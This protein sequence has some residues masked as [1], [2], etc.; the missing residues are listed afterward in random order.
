MDIYQKYSQALETAIGLIQSEKLDPT[1]ALQKTAEIMDLE[2]P[3]VEYVASQLNNSRALVHMA[4][5]S[6]ESRLAP[7]PLADSSKVKTKADRKPKKAEVCKKAS[8]D[9]IF[10]PLLDL[11]LRGITKTAHAEPAPTKVDPF[12]EFDSVLQA[13]KDLLEATLRLHRAYADDVKRLRNRCSDTANAIVHTAGSDDFQEIHRKS[14]RGS[15][16]RVSAAKLASTYENLKNAEYAVTNVQHLAGTGFTSDFLANSAALGLSKRLMSSSTSLNNASMQADLVTGDRIKDMGLAD[17]S[18]VTAAKLDGLRTRKVFMDAVF[19]DPGLRG[20]PLAKLVQAF[21]DTVQTDPSIVRSPPRIRAGMMQM[22]QSSV[23][24]PFQLG[25]M[26]DT[27]KK[28]QAIFKEIRNARETFKDDIKAVN[29]KAA[30]KMAERATATQ[31]AEALAKAEAEKNTLGGAL[32]ELGTGLRTLAAVPE[33]YQTRA[34]EERRLSSLFNSYSAEDLEAVAKANGFKSAYD[35]KTV[36]LR[37][38]KRN[39]GSSLGSATKSALTGIQSLQTP[40]EKAAAEANIKREEA[41]ID[42]LLNSLDAADQETLAKEN[43]FADASQMRQAMMQKVRDTAGKSPVTGDTAVDSAAKGLK[44]LKTPEEKA[45]DA[46]LLQRE[47][48]RINRYFQ[49]YTPEELEAVALENG[50]SSVDEYK[51]ELLRQARENPGKS[52]ISKFDATRAAVS[53]MD[54][55]DDMRNT[56]AKDRDKVADKVIESK[57]KEIGKIDRTYLNQAVKLADEELKAAARGNP[58]APFSLHEL[59]SSAL[60]TLDADATSEF[61]AKMAEI[62]ARARAMKFADDVSGKARRSGGSKLTPEQIAAIQEVEFRTRLDPTAPIDPTAAGVA[63]AALR[64]YEGARLMEEAVKVERQMKV[65][66]SVSQKKAAED[67]ARQ[68]GMTYAELLSTLAASE[69]PGGV[70]PSIPNGS[71]PGLVRQLVDSMIQNGDPLA[72]E[73]QDMLSRVPSLIDT[74]NADG[75]TVFRKVI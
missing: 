47:E 26:V 58:R 70:V 24:D 25:Q 56:M 43:G 29:T 9:N 33:Q 44:N 4:T 60:S 46:E 32:K 68:F 49:A 17:M 7:F 13:E 14:P 73:Y 27:G 62:E 42:R 2:R 39:P 41:R 51:Q 37:D 72:G 48:Y 3:G 71:P 38:A 1:Q 11:P 69:T 74:V 61:A 5:T 35:M 66:G 34:R 59:A 67:A 21:N 16:V 63:D 64:Q 30:T 8:A 20:Y 54:A 40:A 19:T 52:P 75:A 28:Q 50:F 6:G 22:L 10:S 65:G 12:R 36:L 57:L 55:M 23:L 15:R 18:P 53:N 45:R 31:A